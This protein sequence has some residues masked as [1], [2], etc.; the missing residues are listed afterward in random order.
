MAA[1]LSLNSML[2]RELKNEVPD[3]VLMQCPEADRTL[4]ENIL[5][6]AQAELVVLNLA[7]TTVCVEGRKITL[8]C[9]LTGPSPSVS[10]S[11]MRNLQAYSPARV[12]D[13]RAALLDG[14]LFLVIELSDSL[15]RIST[16]ELEV[17][18]VLK[19]RRIIDRLMGT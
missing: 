1:P 2:Q 11:T 6:V 7:S 4:A 13:L 8:K 9:V 17:V 10:L 16:T 18:R 3:A 14:H 15:T 19:K 12:L 5:R